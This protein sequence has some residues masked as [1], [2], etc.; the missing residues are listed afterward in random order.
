MTRE[1]TKKIIMIISASFPNWKPQDLSFTVDTWHMML[2]DYSYEQIAIALK[3]YIATDSSGF[4]PSIGQLIN[5]LHTVSTPRELSEMEAWGLVSRALRNGYYGAEEEFAKLPPVIQK[6]IGSSSQ[7]RNW[8]QTDAE[9]V[10]N[11]IQSNFM[12]NYRTVL[13]R[14]T[15]YS[16]M[17]EDVKRLIQKV[18]GLLEVKE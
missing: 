7:L 5:K 9:S 14:E 8:S 6:T 16:K 13:A 10:E 15:E 4:A 17:P 12:R 1:E 18:N 3:T 11:V 2:N